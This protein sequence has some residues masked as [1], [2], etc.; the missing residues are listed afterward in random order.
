MIV[1]SSRLGDIY[2]FG[3][4]YSHHCSKSKGLGMIGIQALIL[5]PSFSPWAP[6]IDRAQSCYL[7]TGGMLRFG[8]LLS[9]REAAGPLSGFNKYPTEPSPPGRLT[10][11]ID[12]LTLSALS[13]TGRSM[14]NPRIKILLIYIRSLY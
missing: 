13:T 12:F 1:Q 6:A 11:G 4:I 7:L 14:I 3:C 8:P 5:H 9:P 2:N 10:P